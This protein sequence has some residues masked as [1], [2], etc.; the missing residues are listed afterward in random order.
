MHSCRRCYEQYQALSKGLALAAN[1]LF[2][3]VGMQMPG[4]TRSLPVT[5]FRNRGRGRGNGSFPSCAQ[6]RWKGAKR[7]HFLR[8]HAFRP[9]GASVIL[10]YRWALDDDAF[11]AIVTTNCWGSGRSR[12]R[13]SNV[14]R[15]MRRRASPKGRFPSGGKT[16]RSPSSSVPADGT[17][18]ASPS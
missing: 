9:I 3:T 17:S 13:A 10:P 15:L 16:A 1:H 7:W 8:E 14:S 4:A 12:V 6:L 5:F 18:R 2:F 11:T